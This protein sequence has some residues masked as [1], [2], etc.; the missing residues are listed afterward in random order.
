M[1]QNRVG[2][3]VALLRIQA[4]YARRAG[5]ERFAV[6]LELAIAELVAPDAAIRSQQTKRGKS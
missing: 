5:R 4:A 6:Q 2:L 1:R 3:E